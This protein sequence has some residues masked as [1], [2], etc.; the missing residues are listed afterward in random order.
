MSNS[1]LIISKF[2]NWAFCRYKKCAPTAK[3]AL[4]LDT[5]DFNADSATAEW[6]VFTS[7]STW[8][9]TAK[10]Q[11][12][13]TALNASPRLE[14]TWPEITRSLIILSRLIIQPRH[15]NIAPGRSTIHN[16]FFLIRKKRIVIAALDE[17]PFMENSDV[18]TKRQEDRRWEI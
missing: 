16:T 1:C 11:R 14:P 4:I 10:G 7:L 6:I 8:W 12:N 5:A 13:R 3:S 17:L 9:V 18:V 2:W 15:Y